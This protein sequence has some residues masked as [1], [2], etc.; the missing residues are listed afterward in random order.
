MDSVKNAIY[1]ALNNI[2]KQMQ[3]SFGFIKSL[4]NGDWKLA[5]E[6]AKIYVLNVCK[7]I[8]DG[9]DGLLQKMPE[10]VNGAI[11]G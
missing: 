6:Y 11:K 3:I 10:L 5:W 1:N 7:K 8:L 4:I 9:L 2:Y